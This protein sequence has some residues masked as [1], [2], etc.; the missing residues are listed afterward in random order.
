MSTAVD[1]GMPLTPWKQVKYW[2]QWYVMMVF[3]ILLRSSNLNFEFQLLS[4]DV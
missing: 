4:V 2:F 3:N 1:A